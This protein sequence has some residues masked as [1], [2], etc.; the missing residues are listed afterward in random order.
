MAFASC[1]I[2]ELSPRLRFRLVLLL[3]LWITKN[4][5]PNPEK[6]NLFLEEFVE[7]SIELSENPIE[8]TSNGKT[9]KIVVCPFCASVDSVARPIATNRVQYSG[10][11]SCSWCYIPGTFENKAIRFFYLSCDGEHPPLRSHEKFIDEGLRAEALN[12]NRTGNRIKTIN[13]IKGFTILSKLPYFDCIWGMCFDYLHTLVLGPVRQVFSI[14]TDP[15]NS[16]EPYYLNARKRQILNSRLMQLTPTHENHRLPREFE[17]GKKPKLKASE[18][19]SWLLYYAYPCLV[20]VLPAKYLES[21][22][23][24][25]RSTYYLLQDSI[26]KEK[27]EQCK[28]DLYRF[29]GECEIFYGTSKIT[30]NLHGLVHIVL[31]IEKNGSLWGNSTFM[32]EGAMCIYKDMSAVP[33][34]KIYK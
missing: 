14:W 29:A 11:Y 2:N 22:M 27:L 31:H 28:R 12:R 6:M 23:L 30:F 20:D 33:Q 7:M 24:L 18:W 5:E 34:D 4:K 10:Y 1:Y 19:K 15:A 17:E 25:S 9:I 16:H 3:A 26:T 13:G 8:I 32:F 21:F